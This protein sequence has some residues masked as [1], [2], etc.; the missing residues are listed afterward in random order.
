MRTIIPIL[1]LVLFLGAARGEEPEQSDVRM[2]GQKIVA[3][4]GGV[5]R[6][7]LMAAISRGGPTN[8][9]EFCSAH[10]LALTQPEEAGA[11]VR[12]V[13]LKARNPENKPDAIEEAA[14][15]QYVEQA[16]R[17]EALLPLVVTNRDQARFFSPIVLDNPLCL[18]CHGRPH[19]QVQSETL[20]LIKKLYPEDQATGFNLGDVRGMWSVT[21]RNKPTKKEP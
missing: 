9:L 7:N 20:D 3:E 15:K 11:E 13:S 6:S 4:V 8:A 21:F 19:E 17:A 5:L 14:L 2:K 18:N 12:R 1:S 10:A 16:K